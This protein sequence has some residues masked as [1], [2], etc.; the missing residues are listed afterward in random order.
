MIGT[1]LRDWAVA[2]GFTPDNEY[3]YRSSHEAMIGNE[4]LTKD[5]VRNLH[6]F[7]VFFERYLINRGGVLKDDSRTGL[8]YNG[9]RSVA[10]IVADLSA[11]TVFAIGTELLRAGLIPLPNLRRGRRRC[12]RC[13]FDQGFGLEQHAGVHIASLMVHDMNRDRPE[14]IHS[15][16]F[17]LWDLN[18][19]K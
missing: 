8:L 10:N 9:A 2:K 13:Q 3:S 11:R 14:T 18:W 4:N 15:T 16:G 1:K 12:N 6:R 7:A 5:Q 19:A 17:F